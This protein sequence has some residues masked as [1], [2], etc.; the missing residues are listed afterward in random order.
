MVV[1]LAIR[2]VIYAPIL[3]IG[4]VIK[5]LNKSASMSWIIALAVIVLL[6]LIGTVF[7]VALPKFKADSK[8]Y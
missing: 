3:G 1:V 7:A 4:G 2:M 6:G 8:T 5:A